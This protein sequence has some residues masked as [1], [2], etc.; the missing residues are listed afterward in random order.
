MINKP[1]IKKLLISSSLLA[2][3]AFTST[4]TLAKRSTPVEV[5]CVNIKKVSYCAPHSVH[6]GG[7]QGGFI[8]AYDKKGNFLWKKRIYK[9]RYNDQLERDIQHVF[10]T[11]ITVK[12]KYLHILNEKMEQYCLNIKTHSSKRC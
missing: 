9:V 10:I 7:Q 2:I 8:V 4:V 1:S 11:S 12:G 5:P 3:T 6:A